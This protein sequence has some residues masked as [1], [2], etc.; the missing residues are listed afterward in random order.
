MSVTFVD[1]GIYLRWTL[2]D[3]ESYAY[4]FLW[5]PGEGWGTWEDRGDRVVRAKRCDEV[6][7]PIEYRRVVAQRQRDDGE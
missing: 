7:V 5:Q 1:N 4:G 2:Y 6:D 3:S